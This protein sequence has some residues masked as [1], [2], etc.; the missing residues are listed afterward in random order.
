VPLTRILHAAGNLR[1]TLA[2]AEHPAIDA[3]EADL[4]VRAGRAYAQHARPLGPLPFALGSRGLHRAAGDRV[5]LPELLAAVDGH[6]ELVIDLRAWFGDPAPDV[7]AAVHRFPGRARLL[8]SCES[9]AIADRLRAWLPDVRVAYS[10]RSE[11][12]LRRYVQGQLD[13]TM[14]PAALMVRH[15]LLHTAAEVAGLRRWA[16]SLGAWTVDAPDRAAELAAWGVD[17]VTSN[18]VDV[19]AGLPR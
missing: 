19:L 10:V 6:A 2:L 13:G 9:W 5:T 12:Q 17:S 8:V 7:A 1:A 3:I 15:S 18:A 4:W 14:E 11:G 16:P